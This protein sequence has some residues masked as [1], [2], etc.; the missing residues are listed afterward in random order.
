[1]RITRRLFRL[2]V[3]T[4]AIVGLVTNV[5]AATSTFSCDGEVALLAGGKQV[6]EKVS[7]KVD[8]SAKALTV[9]GVTFPTFGRTDT[10]TIV[11][12]EPNRGV[13]HFQQ[14]YRRSQRPPHCI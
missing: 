5:S 11:A 8:L 1:M 4:T 13:R 12:M 9:D 14:D 10:E 7:V 6:G 2:W 3:F